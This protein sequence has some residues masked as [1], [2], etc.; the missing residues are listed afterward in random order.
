MVYWHIPTSFVHCIKKCFKSNKF[1]SVTWNLITSWNSVHLQKPTLAQWVT[2]FPTW[3]LI[4]ALTQS[5]PLA[6]FL[7]HINHEHTLLPDFLKN[8]FNIILISTPRTFEWFFFPSGSQRKFLYTFLAYAVHATTPTVWAPCRQLTT[9]HR[10]GP[11]CYDFNTKQTHFWRASQDVVVS[12]GWL[13]VYF[14][15]LFQ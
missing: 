6:Y 13:V 1:Q 4:A 8:Y 5:P 3:R 15:T 10:K 7:S 11:A 9:A 12:S 2:A 14:T